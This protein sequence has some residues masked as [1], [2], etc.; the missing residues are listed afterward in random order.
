[1]SHGE[2]TAADLSERLG[3]TAVGA[4][5]VSFAS[6][7]CPTLCRSEFA[8]FQALGNDLRVERLEHVPSGVQ[9]CSYRITPVGT[10]S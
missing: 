10:P 5:S 1:M 6:A 3:M 4:R 7:S 2:Q 8:T 9:R